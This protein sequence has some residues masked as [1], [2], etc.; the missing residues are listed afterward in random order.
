MFCSALQFQTWCE[1]SLGEAEEVVTKEQ[2][3]ESGEP[4]TKTRNV[5]EVEAKELHHVQAP[6]IYNCDTQIKRL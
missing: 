3:L 1:L 4:G 5:F 2:G 6:R